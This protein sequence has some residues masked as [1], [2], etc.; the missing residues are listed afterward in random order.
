MIRRPC[1]LTGS[2]CA[3]PPCADAISAAMASP[4]P[5]PGRRDG[6]PAAVREYQANYARELSKLPALVRTASATPAPIAGRSWPSGHA[7]GAHSRPLLISNVSMAGWT[8][9]AA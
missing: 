3:V 7:G 5:E 8:P 2:A 9:R 1:G 6:A 4:R